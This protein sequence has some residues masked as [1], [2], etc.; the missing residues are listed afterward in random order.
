MDKKKNI[1]SHGYLVDHH[2]QTTDE[3]MLTHNNNNAIASA[4]NIIETKK[5]MDPTPY[6]LFPPPRSKTNDRHS[7]RGKVFPPPPRS[8]TIKAFIGTFANDRCRMSHKTPRTSERSRRL[9]RH[10]RTSEAIK[11]TFANA[12]ED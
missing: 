11:A 4:R 5:G 8:K 10:L 12:R 3:S 2:H 6:E 1:P 9:L 7:E